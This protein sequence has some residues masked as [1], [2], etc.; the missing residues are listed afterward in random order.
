YRITAEEL[1]TL[2]ERVRTL[3]GRGE[4]AGR[5]R[6]E[7]P[8]EQEGEGAPPN[9]SWAPPK[10]SWAPPDPPHAPLPAP[11]P[12]LPASAP[13]VPPSCPPLPAWWPPLPAPCASLPA[14]CP[15]LPTCY[16]RLCLEMLGLSRGMSLAWAA[17]PQQGGVEDACAQVRPGEGGR[18]CPRADGG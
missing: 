5:G 2:G 10:A 9:A 3:A 8:G 15:P 13:P 4:R 1:G 16:A 14:S 18:P 12:P 17:P 6:I 11:G 7:A